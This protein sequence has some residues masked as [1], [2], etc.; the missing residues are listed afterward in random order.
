MQ[1][2]CWNWNKKQIGK[3]ER[4]SLGR[5]TL[6]HNRTLPKAQWTRGFILW[7][8]ISQQQDN[9]ELWPYNYKL[10]PKLWKAVTRLSNMWSKSQ[11]QGSVSCWKKNTIGLAFATAL[12]LYILLLYYFISG[13]N[14]KRWVGKCV[15]YYEGRAGWV[16]AQN[17]LLQEAQCQCDRKS[18]SCLVKILVKPLKKI[19]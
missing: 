2:I 4:R 7:Q 3:S 15:R 5:G 18:W 11:Q 9:P 12:F 8:C 16:L 10:W 13:E 6:P 1:W 14:A 19:A 17:T